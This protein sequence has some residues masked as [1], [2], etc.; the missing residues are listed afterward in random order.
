MS[1]QD[2]QSA[3]YLNKKVLSLHSHSASDQKYLEVKSEVIILT[4]WN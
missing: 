3:K 1:K 4:V 2:V